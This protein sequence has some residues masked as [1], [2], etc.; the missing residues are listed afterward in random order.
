MD[1]GTRG[2]RRYWR[3]QA[4]RILGHVLVSKTVQLTEQRRL[5][6]FRL[7]DAAPQSGQG[8]KD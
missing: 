3:V 6:N 8:P 7:T 4:L 5:E 2:P 1:A